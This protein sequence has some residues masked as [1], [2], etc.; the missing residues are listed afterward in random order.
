SDMDVREHDLAAANTEVELVFRNGV[1]VGPVRTTGRTINEVHVNAGVKWVDGAPLACLHNVQL[2]GAG[3]KWAGN[4]EFDGHSYSGQ[5]DM[6]LSGD[7]CHMV[8]V[9]HATSIETKPGNLFR[10]WGEMIE[11]DVGTLFSGVGLGY[12]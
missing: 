10:C 4:Y 9:P 8:T 5:D 11:D 12:V 1:N 6:D 3:L 2:R 7:M